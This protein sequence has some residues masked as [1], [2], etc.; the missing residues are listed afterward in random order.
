MTNQ[1]LPGIVT[2]AIAL[3]S[4]A[5]IAQ[6][7]Y[8]ARAV[9]LIVPF[10]AG[11]VAD[12]SARFMARTLSEK[13]GQPIVVDNRGGAGGTIGA[14]TV[15]KAKP[16]G[17]TILYGTSGP[18][19]G[20][21]AMA[22]PPSY[23]PLKDF[24]PVYGM[25]ETPML[26]VANS[27]QPY[28][29]FPELMEYAKTN[30]G[31][32]NYG[33]PGPATSPH[34]AG[35]LLQMTSGVQM[36]HIPYRGMGPAMNELIGGSIDIMFDYA[37]TSAAQVKAGRLIML[38]VSSRVRVPALPDVPTIAEQGYPDVVLSPWSGIFVP[39][40]TPPEVV[41]TLAQAMAETMNSP[42][43]KEH[44]FNG[45]SVEMNLPPTE[46]AAFIEAEI[47]K[48]DTLIQRSGSGG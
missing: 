11:G 43:V 33:S 40:G 3:T 31:K 46:F 6:D 28:K 35:E 1:L 26:L 37:S 44:T 38:G 12:N 2:F 5:V 30:V 15:A 22:T 20:S 10:A 13:L 39:N 4:G 25:S 24:I 19:V 45:G 42:S 27:S 36:M 18:M 34:L 16:D 14:E 17:Y 7:K 47:P 8:P 9:T 48:W 23:H 41:D 32:V 29:T 21:L